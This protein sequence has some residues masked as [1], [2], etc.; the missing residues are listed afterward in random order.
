MAYAIERGFKMRRLLVALV[1]ISSV[2]SCTACRNNEKE[3]DKIIKYESGIFHDKNWSEAIGTYRGKAVIPDEET[4]L[5]IA[6]RRR[7]LCHNLS[8]TIIKMK[9]G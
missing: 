1:I 2:I 7:N 4:A 5:K 9:Y 8:F 6:K 3:N